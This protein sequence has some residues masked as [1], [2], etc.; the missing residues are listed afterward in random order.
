MIAL[1]KFFF[2]WFLLIYIVL[3]PLMIFYAL[4]Y[5]FSPDREQGV[6][7]TGMI[8]LQSLPARAAVT[9]NGKTIQ[10]VTPLTLGDLMPGMYSL[11]VSSPGYETWAKSVRVDA[12]KATVLDQILLIPSRLPAEVLVDGKFELFIPLSGTRYLLLSPGERL[13]DVTVYDWKDESGN[14]LLEEV[15]SEREAEIAAWTVMPES[16]HVMFEVKHNSR[17]RFLWI[18]LDKKTA[19]K[20]VT[21]LLANFPHP[22]FFWGPEDPEYLFC[23][24]GRHLSLLNLREMAVYPNFCGMVYG[25]GVSQGKL[26]ALKDS[27]VITM[28]VAA[29][30]RR[31]TVI[32]DADFI[33]SLFD[34]E[35]EYAIHGVADDLAV[36]LGRNG[37]FLTNRLPYRFAEEGVRGFSFLEKPEK[38]LVWK[39][40]VLGVLDLSKSKVRRRFF[41]LGLKTDWINV[42]GKSIEQAFWVHDGAYVLFRDRNKVY[43]IDVGSGY[44]N[45]PA[46]ILTVKPDTPIFYTDETGKVYYLD[47]EKGRLMS[48]K[49]LPDERFLARKIARAIEDTT[50]EFEEKVSSETAVTP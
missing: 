24:S 34:S 44:D 50:A 45:L 11:S 21:K 14:P 36:L 46:E 3:C 37:E 7:K 25:Y 8:H 32:E 6:I 18:P 20:D 48:A 13:G 49:I 12:G 29:K 35:N 28:D 23:Y 39:K 26:Y 15:S 19:I 27:S 9:L 16:E 30:P 1:R 5:I 10:D 33:K 17:R 42:G 47:A 38:L 41:E 22:R 31:I 40:D 2:Y 4:G 43:L